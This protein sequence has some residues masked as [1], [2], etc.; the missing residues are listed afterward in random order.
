[1]FKKS[2]VSLMNAKIKED[3]FYKSRAQMLFTVLSLRALIPF[4]HV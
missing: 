4:S 1:M 3:A 2:E